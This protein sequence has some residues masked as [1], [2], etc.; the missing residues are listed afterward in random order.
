MMKFSTCALLTTVLLTQTRAAEAK[1][2]KGAEVYS[3]QSVLHGRMEMR[4]RMIRGS[5]LLSTFFTYKNG[6]ET[7]G[8]AWEE[9]DIEVLGK[10]DAKSWQSNLITG[11]PRMTSEQVYTAPSSLADGYH[12][13]TLEWTPNYVSWS[14][15]GTLVRKTEGGQAS[16][17]IAAET[18][19]FNAW[20]SDSSGW[21]GALDDTALP[22][23]QF[24]DWIKYYRYENGQFVLDWTDDFDS[25]D[26]SRWSK[27]NWTFDG[28]LVDF[29]PANAV[30]QDGTLI[31][32]I[33]KEGATG[34]SG[35]VPGSD[36]G[37]A[38]GGSQQHGTTGLC[39]T[40]LALGLAA[41]RRRR[42]RQ[43][44]IITAHWLAISKTRLTWAALLVGVLAPTA[45]SATQSAELYRTQAYFYGRFEARV[46]YA[47]GEGVVSSFFL[48]KD[49]SSSTTSWN[50]L[51][52]EKIN[53]TCLMQTN[54][55]TARGTQSAVTT[56]PAFDICGGYHTYTFEWTPDYI[57]WLID[58]T[59]LRRVTGA[60]VTEYTQNAS[61]G[62][63]IHFNLWPGDASF[64]GTFNASVLP[65]RQYISWVSYSSYANGGFQQQWREEFTAST[66]PSGWAVGNWTSPLNHST[67]NPA[68]VSFVNGIA[69]LSMTADGA[70]GFTGTPPA[71]TSGTGGA[72]GTGGR[73]GAGGTGGGGSGGAG[74][75]AAGRGGAGGTSGSGGRGGTGGG[76]SPGS[77]GTSSTGGTGAVGTAGNGAG[78]MAAGTAGNG[79]GG[80]AA[81]TAGNG[82]GGMAAGTAGSGTGGPSG[83]AGASGTGGASAPG[84]GGATATGGTSGN[85]AS[86][87]AGD[88][89]G[90]GDGC[91]CHAAGDQRTGGGGV[92]A[93]LLI[94]ACALERRQ[95]IAERA[96]L[97]A[98][99]SAADR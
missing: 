40:L 38:I 32:A 11:N 15:D 12:T 77:G 91:S 9:T 52:Y 57:A 82:A 29:D 30:V 78:G 66:T 58:G 16:N 39:A 2:Y 27:A 35:T 46:R 75:G 70:T 37:C 24:V 86:G 56:T 31:L 90:S 83:S 73:G 61:Q 95:R 13:Y 33:T 28:N 64:G 51:D 3:L 50:E 81:G 80:M 1:A 63:T 59:Q 72:S 84:G 49:G 48:W 8:T 74:T 54:I 6:S 76:A 45:A 67:H 36:S 5:G 62:M 94:A 88:S 10:N 34:I 96:R 20:A 68:N 53:A 43:K 92:I 87:G 65:V 47:P 98:R 23:Y 85:G 4:M 26:S 89:T 60:S 21:A 19:R 7:T 25:F 44:Q 79:A 69:V 17:L 71:D 93:I 14:F 42:C 55:W 97:R 22:A 41:G 99:T 18:L